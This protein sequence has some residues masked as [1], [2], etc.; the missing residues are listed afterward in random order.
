MARGLYAHF[1]NLFTTSGQKMIEKRGVARRATKMMGQ[2][3]YCVDVLNDI[4]KEHPWISPGH[5]KPQSP[6]GLRHFETLKKFVRIG[7]IALK[8][9]V[10]NA[11]AR[12]T[13]FIIGY[14]A[15]AE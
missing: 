10:E 6:H 5:I 14:G 8:A 1:E 4:G 11:T 13:I 2:D 3:W 15:K 12:P 7:I 9:K